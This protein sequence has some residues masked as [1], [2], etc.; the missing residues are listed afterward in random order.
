MIQEGADQ[1]MTT[2]R[3]V[4]IGELLSWPGVT[5]QPHRFGGIGF[6]YKGKEIGHL[7]GDRLV[8]LLLPKSVRDQ[9]VAAG[10]AHPHHMY[11]DSG[12]VSVYLES[13]KDIS[14]AVELLRFKYDDLVKK[15]S[16]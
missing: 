16:K 14:K 4:L 8:D 13:D 7:H 15:D 2:L 12:W 1:K 11:P 10:R 6:L 9:A 3:E 5:H